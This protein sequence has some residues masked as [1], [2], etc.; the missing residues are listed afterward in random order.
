MTDR[1]QQAAVAAAFVSLSLGA[2]ACRAEAGASAA[3]AD[4]SKWR[5]E[6]MT[7]YVKPSD[8]ELKQR[9]TPMQY[10]VTQ[11]EGTEPPFDNEYWDN[12]QHRHL[13]RRRLRRAALLVARQVR[14]R[15]RL[16]ELHASRSSPDNVDER[17]D[18]KALDDPHRGAL[19]ARR[20]APRPCLRR[21]PGADRPALLHE[22]GGAAL[23]A[24][25]RARGD[26]GYGE[27]LPLFE[28]AGVARQ[29]LRP[30]RDRRFSPAAAS[31]AWR[32]SSA[33]SP[34]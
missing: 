20:L 1:L 13:R 23:R 12:K 25:R 33:T 7:D 21:R 11:H 4:A 26:E 15:H 30:A 9:L 3:V 24:G 17:E 28:K 27:Y 31:G 34:A 16:A 5:E 19:E 32:R 22:L 29:G 8:E 18:R 10:K 14:L 2:L 6:A